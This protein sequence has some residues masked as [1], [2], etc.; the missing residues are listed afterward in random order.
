MPV[1]APD[2]TPAGVAA[3]RCARLGECAALRHIHHRPG[4]LTRSTRAR[5]STRWPWP[6]TPPTFLGRDDDHRTATRSTRRAGRPQA[7]PLV[8]SCAGRRLRGRSD[9]PGHHDGRQPPADVR[10]NHGRAQGAS[11]RCGTSARGPESVSR[12]AAAGRPRW[13]RGATSRRR[14]ADGTAE[15]PPAPP[16]APVVVRN[17]APAPA[18]PA[19]PPPVAPPP[20][21]R[22]HRYPVAPTDCAATPHFLRPGA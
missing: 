9:A 2:R 6:M 12:R 7:V 22:R 8:G 10:A 15:D 5:W 21:L 18:A 4:L 14:A 19:P 3:R 20:A 11:E 16:P 13:S 1:I 17:A